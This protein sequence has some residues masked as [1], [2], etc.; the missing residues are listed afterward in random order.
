MSFDAIYLCIL[1][2]ILFFS[3]IQALVCEVAGALAS[4]NLAC[5]IDYVILFLRFYYIEYLNYTHVM[6]PFLFFV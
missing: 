3:G 2:F 4:K 1:F 6:P 5:H